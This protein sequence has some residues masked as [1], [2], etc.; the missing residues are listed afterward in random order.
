MSW[1]SEHAGGIG[2]LLGGG[3]GFFM[4]GPPGAMLGASLGGA[5]G[6]LMQE[7]SYEDPSTRVYDPFKG[8]R[9]Y[10]GQQ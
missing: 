8:Y 6:G 7:D 1:L 2:T 5:A 9:G 3:L 4:G 10:F